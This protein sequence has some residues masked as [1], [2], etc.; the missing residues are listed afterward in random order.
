M[1]L[2]KEIDDLSSIFRTPLE[3]QGV[4]EALVTRFTDRHGMAAAGV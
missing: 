1:N 3:P 2:I 4:I